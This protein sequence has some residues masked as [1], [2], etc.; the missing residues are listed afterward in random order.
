M[1]TLAVRINEEVFV[2]RV[3]TRVLLCVLLSICSFSIAGTP[4]GPSMVNPEKSFN[5]NE[6][7]E[8]NVVRHVFRV[9]NRGNEPLEIKDVNPG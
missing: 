9:L 5:F 2:K 1:G 7:E 6:V 4:S 8:G 3:F